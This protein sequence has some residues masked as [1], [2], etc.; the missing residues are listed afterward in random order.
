MRK[1]NQAGVDL[2][3]YYESLRLTAYRDLKGILTIGY[4]H[5]GPDVFDG[6]IIDQPSAELLLKHDLSTAESAVINCVRSELT[7]NQ[8]SACVSLVYNI[9][10]TAFAKSTLVKL[11]NQKDYTGAA[12]QFLVWD[13]ANGQVIGGLL[14]RRRAEADL[15]NRS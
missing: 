11:L 7:D 9:G 1:T 13:K 8:F 2:V 15:F 3:K 5:T 10:A 6:Q 14:A 12:Q 4:G